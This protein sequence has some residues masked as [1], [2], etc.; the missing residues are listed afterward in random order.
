MKR[1]EMK[2]LFLFFLIF[3]VTII[4]PLLAADK[5]VKPVILS[6][7]SLATRDGLTVPSFRLNDGGFIQLPRP[8]P[9]FSLD[10]NDT[11]YYSS[12]A[13]TTDQGDKFIFDLPKSLQVKIVID[14]KFQ[15]GWKALLN[16][17]NLSLDSLFL[18]NIVPFGKSTDRLYLTAAGPWS[19]ARTKIFRPGLGPVGVVLPDNA[20]ET[21]FSEIR[22]GD[23]NH[24][25]AIARRTN[26]EGGEKRRWYTKLPPQSS[27]EYTLY[28]EH[29][30]GDWQNGLRLM[31]Q[32][33]FLYDLEIFDNR[34]YE[35]QDLSWIRG[36][37]IITTQMAW[38]HDFYDQ[39]NGG[40][41]FADYLQMGQQLFGGWD[42]Y[43][44]W[45]TWPTLGLDQ[46]N[47]W[48]LYGD[49]PGGLPKLRELAD[50][51]RRQGTKF[52]IS[53]NPWDQSTRQVDPYQGMAELIQATDA[54]GVILD[55]YGWS[56]QDL[57]AAADRIKPGVVMYS[58]GMAVPKDMP[59]I[60]TGRV[61]DAIYMPPPLN[62]NKFIKPDNTIFRV[63][64]LADGELHRETAVAFF[65][66]YGLE[67]NVY[68]PGRPAWM[69][70]E[71]LYLGKLVRI[72]RENS[73]AFYSQDWT[74]LISTLT[75]SIWVNHWPAPN[76]TI[77]TVFSLIPE[78]FTGP[79]F[80]GDL[81][82]VSHW[83]SLYHHEQIQPE[84]VN[85][86]LY[87][88]VRT[89]AFNRSWLN[90]RKEGQVDC[91]ARLPELLEVGLEQDYLTLEASTG[92][93]IKVWTGIPSYQSTPKI[94]PVKKQM[95]NLPDEFGRYEGK[96]V[97]QLFQGGE[98]LDERVVNL[99]MQTPRLISKVIRTPTAG[100]TPIGMVEIKGTDH[101]VFKNEDDQG[102]IP[103]LTFPNGK[104]IK[105]N[106]FFMDK[107]PVTNQQFKVFFEAT[108]YSPDDT[109][110]FLKHWK[111][112]NY[113]P[114]EG[115]YPVVQVSWEDAYAYARWAGKRLP[116]E[117]EWQYA[118]QGGDTVQWP[119]G[120]GFDSS[121]CNV[122]L[123]HATVVDSFTTGGSPFGVL[124]LVG[125]VW[126][127]TNDIYDNGAYY[128]IIIRG[129]SYYYPTSSWW[130]VKGGP[131]PL[132]KTQM[133]LRV[134]PGFE[135]NATVGFRCVKDRE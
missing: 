107:F 109:V 118:A 133:L 17:K 58:E 75:D 99:P 37:Y 15:N 87:I 18:S 91:I 43:I 84:T 135:R 23:G 21:G 12:D 98:L 72:L 116:T 79:L 130:Y 131:Q 5:K 57:Q 71:Y 114:G 74:P 50:F 41:K 126:Q 49:I 7:L 22:S 45:P 65:N 13:R 66:G 20:W 63:G 32:E 33:R 97:I 61:H 1:A 60:I 2:N 53:Y 47:Q 100:E 119:W 68:R 110:N 102:I 93:Q 128:F 34:L 10:I 96:L 104:S 28:A 82:S 121:R 80:Q 19:L 106:S 52:F 124:D 38:D 125:N 73:S 42:A 77:Y 3:V 101:Y 11:T 76:K 44:F 108:R 115:N 8:V 123:D 134:S 132:N 54:D 24:L 26:L 6:E 85:G 30:S 36:C 4:S 105:I 88:P 14:K 35:R 31:F 86:K 94:Y 122:G 56:T 92:D 129:G 117:L 113:P 51:S 25:C 64:Q 83:V 112:G 29:F 70:E 78:G 9:L 69:K 59:G 16:F 40:Y 55:T 62:L 89:D 127:L 103:Y 95:I 90:S 120:N 48:N 46:R 27:V 67:M 111:N 39:Q 81:D